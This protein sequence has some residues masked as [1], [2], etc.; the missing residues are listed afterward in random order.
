MGKRRSRKAPPKKATVKLPTS[1]DCPFCN[2]GG[3]VVVKLGKIAQ[4]GHLEC[5]ICGVKSETRITHLTK[6]I[7]V[8]CEWMDSCAEAN[9]DDDEGFSD[10]EEDAEELKRR[11]VVCL[12]LYCYHLPAINTQ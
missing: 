5:R 7:D 10:L 2:H 4:V 3:T 6:E 9:K 12:A 1:F 11:K 8:Y